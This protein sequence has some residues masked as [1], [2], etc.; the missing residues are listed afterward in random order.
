MVLF[1]T[2]SATPMGASAHES[3]GI[4]VY[5]ASCVTVHDVQLLWVMLALAQ[6]MPHSSAMPVTLFPHT[7]DCHL[8]RV[9]RSGHIVRHVGASTSLPSKA[10][11]MLVSWALL[12]ATTLVVAVCPYYGPK[13]LTIRCCPNTVLS[14]D[15]N[16]V[17]RQ[18]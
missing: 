12:A 9:R 2:K 8:V 1:G 14:G 6:Q 16:R 17:D 4:V 3:K 13:F 10:R 5:R 11:S 7:Y 15:A 18:Q